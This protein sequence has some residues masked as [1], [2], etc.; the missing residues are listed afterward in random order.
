MLMTAY[1]ASIGGSLTPIGAPPNLIIVGFLSEMSHIY[2]SFF[3]WMVWGAV[4][5][6]LYFI[7]AYV[8]LARMYP[9]EVSEI[10]GADEFIAARRQEL[11][12]GRGPR[13]IR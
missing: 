7:I 5:T 10:A 13:K 3:D 8:V 9:L 6:I 11:G 12:N 4:S 1:A 2:V